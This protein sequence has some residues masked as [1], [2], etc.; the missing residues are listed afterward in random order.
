MEPIIKLKNK[1]LK[2]GWDIDLHYM[3]VFQN[4]GHTIS[5]HL[6]LSG[7]ITIEDVINIQNLYRDRL[8][9]TKSHIGIYSN[10]IFLLNMAVVSEI[11]KLLKNE[12]SN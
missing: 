11:Y 1:L 9:S 4:T 2:Y 3:E 12:S 8:Y 7:V 5:F 6:C 10:Q